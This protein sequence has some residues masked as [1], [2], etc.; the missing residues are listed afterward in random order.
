[1]TLGPIALHSAYSRSRTSIQTEFERQP[2]AGDIHHYNRYEREDGAQTRITSG[3]GSAFLYP[4]HNLPQKI[5]WPEVDGVQTYEQRATYPG[6]KTSKRLRWRILLAPF[7][8]PSFIFFVGGLYLLFAISL[9]DSLAVPPQ[10][11]PE[12]LRYIDLQELQQYSVV[13]GGMVILFVILL[14]GFIGF[15]NFGTLWGKVLAGSW[16][17]LLQLQGLIWVAWVASKWGPAPDTVLFQFAEPTF[18][19]RVNAFAV[20]YALTVVV[21]GGLLGS[22][23]YTLYL[24]V[25]QVAFKKHPTHAYSAFRWEHHRNFLR[26]HIDHAGVLTIYPIGVRRVPRRWRYVA[27]ADREPSQGWFEPVDRPIEPHLVEAPLRFDPNGSVEPG[28]REV[29]ENA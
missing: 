3:S 22:Y 4:T 6:A 1:M 8:N 21:L 23:I 14:V 24:F 12:S 16:H 27:E 5:H 11:L 2:L 20:T 25:M 17:A 28:R 10:G 26:L 15:A 7:L 19:I 29:S 13:S 9:A 18:D